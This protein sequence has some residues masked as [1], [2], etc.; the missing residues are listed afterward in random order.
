MRLILYGFIKSLSHFFVPK[1]MP[2]P[3]TRE[4]LSDRGKPCP[5]GLLVYFNVIS[6]VNQH[7]S[8][9]LHIPHSV[10]ISLSQHYIQQRHKQFL[11]CAV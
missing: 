6:A 1:K 10:I 2:A 9:T 3:F 8:T 11:V 5:Y 4:P 7:I